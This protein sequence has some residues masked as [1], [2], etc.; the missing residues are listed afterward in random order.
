MLRACDNPFAVHRV[1]RQRYRLD[2]AQWEQLFARL[3]AQGRRG[4]FVGP[5]GV[6]KTTLLEDLAVRLKA[7]GWEIRL[8]RLNAERN[9]F[10][11]R[12]LR[13]QLE[14]VS[15]RDFV[16]LDGAEQL[17]AV[18]WW[19]F[20]FWTRRAGGLVITSHRAGRLPLLRRCTTSPALLHEL[21]TSLGV[22]FSPEKSATLHTRHR[23]NLRSALRE[24]YDAQAN[25]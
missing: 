12:S 8:L 18:A 15:P 24:L 19:R 6:G 10:T 14:G 3:E 9:Q 4:A 13:A 1:L 11:L 23:G 21:V 16:L 25:T 17:S 22:K 7:R 5:Q 20:R 2:D